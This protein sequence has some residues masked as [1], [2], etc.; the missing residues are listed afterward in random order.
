MQIESTRSVRRTATALFAVLLPSWAL[1]V[2]ATP[3][4]PVL[5]GPTGFASE[6]TWRGPPVELRRISIRAEL[7]PDMA[8]IEQTYTVSNPGAPVT[9]TMGLRYRSPVDNE[10]DLQLPLAAQGWIDGKPLPTE[11]VQVQALLKTEEFGA[12]WQLPVQ[13]RLDEGE[14]ILSLVIVVA[15]VPIERNSRGISRPSQAVASLHLEGDYSA[16][17]WSLGDE[18]PAPEVATALSLSSD[19]PANS[20]HAVQWMAGAVRN[21]ST[22]YWKRLPNITIRYDA[23][24]DAFRA[25]TVDG[26]WR[27]ARKATDRTVRGH[28]D[29]PASALAIDPPGRAMGE[30]PIDPA[31]TRRAMLV[32]AVVLLA[33]L[34]A[35]YVFRRRWE[36]RL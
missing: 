27:R 10:L 32:P 11:N 29:I 25:R 36:K 14:S 24:P 9:V 1:P 20:L 19:I 28:I 2:E 26:L 30:E 16:W 35:A 15:T 33:L 17:G 23:V 7:L 12:G 18:V 3:T 13:C 6:P 21:E 31:R 8:V 34:A 4:V 5:Q 22:T